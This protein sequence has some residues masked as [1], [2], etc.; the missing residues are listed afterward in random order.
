VLDPNENAYFAAR[1]DWYVTWTYD[2]S[3]SADGCT[4]ASPAVSLRLRFVVPAWRAP[5]EPR[6]DVVKE[7]NRFFA[8]LWRHERGHVG[9]AIRAAREID[10]SLADLRAASDCDELEARAD[11]WGERTV[12]RFRSK[13]RAYDE[14]TAHGQTEGALLLP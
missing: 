13:E 9:F 3:S 12:R 6:D 10:R 1:T 4:I 14:A 8:A 7:W 2:Y 5:K 11:A